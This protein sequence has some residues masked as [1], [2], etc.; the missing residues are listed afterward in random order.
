MDRI[1]ENIRIVPRT[2]PKKQEASYLN[3]VAGFFR[4]HGWQNSYT[5]AP[6]NL[7]SSHFLYQV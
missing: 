5:E 7:D 1:S 3:W 6:P 2:P 4:L